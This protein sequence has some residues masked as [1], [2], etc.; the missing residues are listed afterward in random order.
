MELLD[1]ATGYVYYRS[2]IGKSRVIEDYRLIHCQDRAHTFIN[3]QLQFIQYDQE[4]GQKKTLT[5]TEESNELVILVENMGR[6]NYSVQMNHQYK[7]IKDGVIVNGAF[8]SE[9]EIYS[10]PMDNL[11]QVD[12]SGHWQTGQP[13]FSKVSFQVDECADTFVELPG[14]GKGFIVING[15]NIG[16]FWERGPQ[17]R[18]YIPA[19][20]LREGNNEAV[21]FES[22]GR[23][24]DMIIFHDQPDLGPN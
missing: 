10:L 12:F 6:V 11:D 20:Y 9:W 14:W 23:V 18:L 16:R 15:H 7:G 13:S 4:I 3:N 1:Q 5:L 22:D 17:R 8:Q 2:Q 24:S 21:I 19:P